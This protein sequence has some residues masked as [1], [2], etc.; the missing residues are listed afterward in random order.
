MVE[1][2]GQGGCAWVHFVFLIWDLE[3]T[4]LVTFRDTFGFVSTVLN[5]VDLRKE[6]NICMGQGLKSMLISYRC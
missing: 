4:V 2:R 5:R 1:G 6:I 3:K